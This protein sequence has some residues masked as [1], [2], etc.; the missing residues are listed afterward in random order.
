MKNAF[1]W[2]V[3]LLL[4]GTSGTAA[5]QSYEGGARGDLSFVW[6]L[7]QGE[8]ADQVGEAG[9]GLTA[10]LGGRIG[11]SPFVM[12]TEVGFLS[13]GTD[14]SLS[15]HSLLVDRP[16]IHTDLPL[17]VVNV[18]TSHTVLMGH[19]VGRLQPAIG[20]V[21]PHLDVLVGL[22]YFLSQTRLVSDIVLDEDGLSSGVDIGDVAFSYGIGGGVDLSLFQGAMGWDDGPVDISMSVGARYLFGSEAE[23]LTRGA[24]REEDGTFVFDVARSRTD[25]LVPQL[26]FHVKF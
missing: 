7:P 23:Y 20:R 26:G 6:A 11:N 13:Y 18:A 12:G 4:L 8:L 24:V 17:E 10:L 2:T 16:G 5:A 22:K 21:H 9:L 19:L 25:L 15:L 3:L 14:E 1:T